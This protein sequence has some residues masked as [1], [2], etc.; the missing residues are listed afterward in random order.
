MSIESTTQTTVRARREAIGLTREELARRADTSTST[1]ARIELE[2]HLPNVSAMVRIAQVLGSTVESLLSSPAS[3]ATPPAV[4][5]ARVPSSPVLDA[6]AGV[7]GGGTSA[8]AA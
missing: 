6:P 4:S 7:E 5:D 3:E 1:V 8:S 2:G